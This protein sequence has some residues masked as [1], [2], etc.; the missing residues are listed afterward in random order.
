[1]FSAPPRSIVDGPRGRVVANE[2]AQRLEVGTSRRMAMA[3]REV[4]AEATALDVLDDV[5]PP[6]ELDVPAAPFVH[7]A[8]PR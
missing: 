8:H 1:M 3:A 7:D 6:V 2:P 5:A 4:D